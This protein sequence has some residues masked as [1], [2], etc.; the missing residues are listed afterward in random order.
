MKDRVHEL[1]GV[2][3]D[4]AVKNAA[5]F[6]DNLQDLQT[7]FAGVGR[8][9]FEQLLP[10]MNEIMAGFTSL[11][12]G[13][14]GASTAIANGFS[15]LFESLGGV[16][17]SII[18]TISE[19]LP[20]MVSTLTEILPDVISMA[21][22]LIIS[23]GKALIDALPNMITTVIPALAGAAIEIVVA[24][25]QALVDAAPQLISAGTQ[26]ISSLK[27]SMN[28]SELLSKGTEI[29][30]NIL[31]GITSALPGILSVGVEVISNVANG[32]LWRE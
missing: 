27:G 28:V 9:I 25:G 19:M 11:I 6:Q 1:G 12:A 8:G 17:Q 20:S 15:T 31:N 5:A 24:L 26:L 30:Q 18:S 13:E 16:T 32:Y 10:G 21:T 4:E 14:E 7:A 29:I 2:M 3:S 22:E 23:L